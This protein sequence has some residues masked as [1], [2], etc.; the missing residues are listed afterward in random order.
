M[1]I[2]NSLYTTSTGK[3]VSSTCMI[4][5]RKTHVYW[6]FRSVPF[7]ITYGD[8]IACNREVEPYDIPIV[9][10]SGEVLVDYYPTEDFDGLVD[11]RSGNV[12]SLD[13]L[14]FV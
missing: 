13:E 9:L 11:N 12:Y 5:W 3:L 8:K 4:G 1:V 14:N 2:L 7:T 10:N 6:G